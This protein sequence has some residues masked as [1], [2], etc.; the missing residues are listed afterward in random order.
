MPPPEPETD[1]PEEKDKRVVDV[2]TQDNN[3]YT[4]PL[5]VGSQNIYNKVVYDTMISWTSINERGA[6]GAI[7]AS[8]YSPRDSITSEP[9]YRE[10]WDP[11]E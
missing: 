6:H 1:F 4:G 10:V 9:I 11:I 3:D 2:E 8:E 5:F 7:Y